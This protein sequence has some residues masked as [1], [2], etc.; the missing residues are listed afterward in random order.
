MSRLLALLPC[1]MPTQNTE[2]TETMFVGG[3]FLRCFSSVAKGCSTKI[4]KAMMT[5]SLYD[6]VL[7]KT[8]DFVH[9]GWVDRPP[10]PLTENEW[11]DFVFA[12]ESELDN[13]T[14]IEQLE[15]SR[16]SAAERATLVPQAINAFIDRQ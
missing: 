3:L 13:S 8:T 1:L 11:V 7:E 12:L 6:E 2:C 14:L 5:K 9:F 4:A 15:L 16:L 10:L